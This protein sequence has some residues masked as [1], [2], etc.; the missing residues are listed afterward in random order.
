M[1]EDEEASLTHRSKLSFDKQHT[2]RRPD[3]VIIQTIVDS[4]IIRTS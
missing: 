4:H 2:E 1:E 3:L